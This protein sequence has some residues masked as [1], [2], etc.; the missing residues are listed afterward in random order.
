MIKGRGAVNAFIRI[1]P[2]EGAQNKLRRA[3]VD[4]F[5]ALLDHDEIISV[6]LLE[7]EFDGPAGGTPP[8]NL[9]DWYV[10][11][12]GTNSDSVDR[13]ARVHFGQLSDD[14]SSLVS[15]GTYRLMWDLAKWDLDKCTP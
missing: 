12:E 8:P 3:L 11:L 9:N 14:L 13:A 10:M 6:H 7:G 5:D 2:A 4:Q 1:R 15:L